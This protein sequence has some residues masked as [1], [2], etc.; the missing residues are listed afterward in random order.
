MSGVLT[1]GAPWKLTS[2]HPK[3]SA[4]IKI[5]F[6]LLLVATIKCIKVANNNP[7][8]MF[9]TVI[10][11]DLRSMATSYLL[12][13]I[14]MVCHLEQLMV[15]HSTPLGHNHGPEQ[16]SI[17]PTRSETPSSS[18]GICFQTAYPDGRVCCDHD[19]HRNRM[20]DGYNQLALDDVGLVVGLDLIPHH[21]NFGCL[22]I[23]KLTKGNSWC[24]KRTLKSVGSQLPSSD[25][26]LHHRGH[27][28][29]L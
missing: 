6:G 18:I 21:D 20:V 13:M 1:W 26:I 4:T 15:C 10:S 5:M 3:S 25:C 7:L 17:S 29:D 24:N 16:N 8:N 12:S 9:E 14:L 22:C 11:I 27:R 2:P 28:T 19:L 23:C